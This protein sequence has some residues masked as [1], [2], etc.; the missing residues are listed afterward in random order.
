MKPAPLQLLQMKNSSRLSLRLYGILLTPNTSTGR[1][2]NQC[3]QLWQLHRSLGCHRLPVLT[4][5]FWSWFHLL[6]FQIIS[7]FLPCPSNLWLLYLITSIAFQYVVVPGRR[8]L[9]NRAARS[10]T[11]SR[12]MIKLYCIISWFQKKLNEKYALLTCE[13]TEFQ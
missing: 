5:W 6:H 4:A 2:I 3:F 8:K 13:W 12:K 1:T 11:V 9:L 10:P 7:R